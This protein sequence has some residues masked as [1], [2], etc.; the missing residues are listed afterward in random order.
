MKKLNPRRELEIDGIYALMLRTGHSSPYSMENEAVA[1]PDFQTIML[2]LLRH[3]AD[4]K[5][6]PNQEISKDTKTSLLE[7]KV[8]KL[9]HK[10]SQKNDVLS[11]L[12]QE[13]V[14]LKKLLGK[15]EW[16][17]GSP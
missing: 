3:I 2:P 1:I 15:T 10:L 7:N 12:M 9:E 14:A 17:L 8:S 6:H 11:E 16:G 5:E 4:G 13:H